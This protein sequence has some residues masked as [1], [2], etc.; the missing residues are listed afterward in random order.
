MVRDGELT[1]LFAKATILATGGAGQVYERTTNPAVATGDG[2]AIA[3]RAG[4][5]L[6]DMEF[7][8]FHP[9]SLYVPGAPHFLLSEAMRG[10][11]AVLRNVH[12]EPFMSNYHPSAELAPR[13]IVSRAIISEMVKTK[14]THVYLDL[15]HLDKEFVKKRFPRIHLTCR[16]YNIDIT[17][18]LVPV[19]PA[20]HYMM[21]GIRTDLNGATSMKGLY[22]AGEVACTGVHGANRL[23]SNSLLEGL[24]FGARAGI[25][26]SRHASDVRKSASPDADA[27]CDSAST[28]L[29]YSPA[30]LEETRA[31]LRKLMWQKAGII[32]CA[33]SLSLAR[34]RLAQWLPAL[35][36]ASVKREEQELK[37]ML[38]V[39]RLIIEAAA[40]RK[41]SVGAHYRSD[42]PQRGDWNRHVMWEK[43]ELQ[44]Q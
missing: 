4:A 24:V 42:Y 16:M 2:M 18:D 8:Q 34:E 15:T 28:S 22:A 43:G 20:A 44:E 26:A 35:D 37:N 7:V 27:F 33:E 30:V 17:G 21:G 13:D 19:S 6:E 40:A 12:R 41:G 10:E 14:S 11:G 32:R 23:A 25:A 9:T 29:H 5:V 31:S 39:S 38:T 1:R 3:F 36:E